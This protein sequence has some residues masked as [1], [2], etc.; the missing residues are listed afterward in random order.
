MLWLEMWR[1]DENIDHGAS[2]M[3]V[4]PLFV[5]TCLQE[6]QKEIT[7]GLLGDHQLDGARDME[8]SDA[9]D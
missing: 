4:R 3:G 6:R 1:D 5:V 7:L 2:G 9:G 8:I